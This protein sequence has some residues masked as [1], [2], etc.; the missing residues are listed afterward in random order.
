MTINVNTMCAKY[1]LLVI[2]GWSRT[3][4]DNIFEQ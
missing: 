4:I 1:T 2:R 3:F